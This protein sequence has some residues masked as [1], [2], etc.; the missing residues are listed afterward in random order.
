MQKLYEGGNSEIIRNNKDFVELVTDVVDIAITEKGIRP[1]S[2]VIDG[3]NFV[4]INISHK[5]HAPGGIDILIPAG[6]AETF[7]ELPLDKSESVKTMI[8]SLRDHGYRGK[9]QRIVDVYQNEYGDYTLD[10]YN[11]IFG[12]EDAKKIP[13]TDPMSDPKIIFEELLEKIFDT[14]I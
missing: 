11:K 1:K 8:Y 4:G 7:G 9:S 14:A 3:N 12:V 6:A 10:S 5:D 13:S 2:K